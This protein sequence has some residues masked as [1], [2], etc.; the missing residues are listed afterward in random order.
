MKLYTADEVT[1]IVNRFCQIKVNPNDQRMLM[2]YLEVM[3]T[4]GSSMDA[5]IDR[6]GKP[7]KSFFLGLFGNEE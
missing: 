5:F 7:Q 4:I 3:Q 6:Y 2:D 1:A